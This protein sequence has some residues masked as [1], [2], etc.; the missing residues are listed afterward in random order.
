MT[1]L[2]LAVVDEFLKR[3]GFTAA[4]VKA[5]ETPA[6]STRR[7]AREL[8]ATGSPVEASTGPMR[9]PLLRMT[10]PIARP[11]TADLSEP[12]WMLPNRRHCES[13]PPLK[14]PRLFVPGG[15]P[16]TLR[17]SARKRHQWID[18]L[19]AVSV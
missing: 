6:P 9:S 2:L 4:A 16:A 19:V 3:H 8:H 14:R 5:A 10:T 11:L 17:R 12:Q 18:D 1:A 13:E 7:P 15:E